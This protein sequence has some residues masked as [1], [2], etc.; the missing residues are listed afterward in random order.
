MKQEDNSTL[1]VTWSLTAGSPAREVDTEMKKAAKVT[2]GFTES[3]HPT[4]QLS[5]E[6]IER[7]A[8]EI[9]LEE[10]KVKKEDKEMEEEEEEER[11]DL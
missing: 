4:K 2:G 10:E 3:K 6:E 8:K 1:R 5:E 7:M 11:S 9:G